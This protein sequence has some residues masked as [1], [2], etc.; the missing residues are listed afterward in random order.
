MSEMVVYD[1]ASIFWSCLSGWEGLL[2]LEGYGWYVSNRETCSSDY[3]GL[4]RFWQQVCIEEALRWFHC[5]RWCRSKVMPHNSTCGHT[6]SLPDFIPQT[7]HSWG[8]SCMVLSCKHLTPPLSMCYTVTFL[9][10]LGNLT[11]STKFGRN[12]M[13]SVLRLVP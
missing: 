13:H 5:I 11:D 12:S 4:G 3:P 8:G 2:D 7:L 9:T 6:Y 10:C 1:T